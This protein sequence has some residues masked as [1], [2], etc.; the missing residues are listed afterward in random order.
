[1]ALRASARAH[2]ALQASSNPARPSQSRLLIV[3]ALQSVFAL[4]ARGSKLVSFSHPR[5][6]LVCE[7][8]RSGTP[9]ADLEA[10][11]R[12]GLH[13][14][15]P[16]SSATRAEHCIQPRPC[17][18]MPWM[19]REG[20]SVSGPFGHT[21]R[22]PALLFLPL[23]CSS[24]LCGTLPPLPPSPSRSGHNTVS[25]L[26]PQRLLFHHQPLRPQYTLHTLAGASPLAGRSD[27]ATSAQAIAVMQR[28]CPDLALGACLPFTPG[29]PAPAGQAPAVRG[30]RSSL[31]PPGLSWFRLQLMTQEQQ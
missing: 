25:S 14:L 17:L 22:V 3:S 31:L 28:L 18:L 24:G 5:P 30:C 4:L 26:N 16:A 11:R 2:P 1:M 15:P 20:A 9:R 23:R 12:G 7:E 6:M 8:I 21:L 13:P 29:T 27:S 10:Q 19:R